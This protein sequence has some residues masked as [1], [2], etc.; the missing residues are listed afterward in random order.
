MISPRLRKRN[1]L[2]LRGDLLAEG[3]V[4]EVIETADLLASLREDVHLP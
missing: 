2:E 3:V 1:L 4:V